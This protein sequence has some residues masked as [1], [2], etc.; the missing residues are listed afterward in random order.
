M[1]E[2]PGVQDEEIVA[3]LHKAYNLHVSEIEFLPLGADRNTAVFRV[4]TQSDETYFVKLR[5]GH[6]DEASVM[7]PKLMFDSGIHGV[8]APVPDGAG[9]LWTRLAEFRLI[10]FPFVHGKS[11]FEQ[12]MTDSQ[13]VELG[14]LLKHLH[15]MN[16]SVTLVTTLPKEDYSSRHRDLVA[17]FMAWEATFADDIA[18]ELVVLLHKEGMVIRELI[19]Q[20]ERLAL[21]LRSQPREFVLCHGDI[22]VGNALLTRDGGLYVVDWDTLILAPKERDLM[23]IGAGLGGGSHTAEQEVQLFY[24]GYGAVQI[25]PVALAYYR[26]E[27]IVQDVAAYCEQILLTTDN[28]L[29][30]AEGLRQLQRQFEQ[31][32]V[33][34]HALRT[35]QSLS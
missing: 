28:L 34:P 31:D 25:D 15:S 32:G 7:L 6:F 13:W 2:R 1:L 22:H 17:R 26:C 20:A 16:L 30:R 10:L 5:S 12:P 9:H 18:G 35:V 29:D 14:S 23:F 19:T 27:R 33:V 21:V 3:C 11:G 24:K 4:L 8:I